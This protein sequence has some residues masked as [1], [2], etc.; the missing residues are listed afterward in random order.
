[1]NEWEELS[2]R[3]AVGGAGD[4]NKSYEHSVNKIYISMCCAIYIPIDT[5]IYLTHG[6]PYKCLLQLG[7][8]RACSQN[9]MY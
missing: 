5:G 8:L 1:M 2:V 4:G 3:G 7:V 9:G 6:K